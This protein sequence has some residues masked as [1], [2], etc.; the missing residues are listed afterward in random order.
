MQDENLDP[1]VR[2]ASVRIPR[3]RL[4][5]LPY[6]ST[7]DL[8]NPRTPRGKFERGQEEAATYSVL[9]PVRPEHGL[10]LSNRQGLHDGSAGDQAHDT[11]LLELP[12]QINSCTLRNFFCAPMSRSGY[13]R[14]RMTIARVANIIR[15]QRTHVAYASLRELGRW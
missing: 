12:R 8:L 14:M 5:P 13:W 6:S 10:L 11:S 7:A 2:R 4:K 3:S 9:Q 15:Q 1:H